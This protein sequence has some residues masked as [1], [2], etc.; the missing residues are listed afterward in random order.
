MC[1]PQLLHA[2][3]DLLAGA[4]VAHDDRVVLTDDDLLSLT[5]VAHGQQAQ[6]VAHAL[7]D[8]PSTDTHGDVAHELVL[9]VSKLRGLDDAQLKTILDDVRRQ[10]VNDVAGAWCYDEQLMPPTDNRLEDGLYRQDI[11]YLVVRHEYIHVLEDALVLL[12]VVDEQLVSVSAVH[13]YAVRH[14]AV[15]VLAHALLDGHQSVLPNL[16]ICLS[17]NSPYDG[18][19]VGRYGSHIFKARGCH[20]AC[21]LSE[22]LDTVCRHGV[23]VPDDTRGIHLIT[24]KRHTPC[25]DSLRQDNSRR[26]A[27]TCRGGSPISR[28]LDHAHSKVLNRMQQVNALGDCHAVL[29]NRNSSCVVLALNDDRLA[30][31]TEGRL[32][33]LT[34]FPDSLT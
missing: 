4:L 23:D 16:F 5:E 17:N 25:S 1:L 31:W 33:S 10:G 3:G 8:E 11:T 2:L 24:N 26:G 9:L 18:V 21:S 27:V 6:V 20:L 34:D 29:S 7:A 28:L 15:C 14:L 32:N 13:A 22:P 12:L 30:P 19:V